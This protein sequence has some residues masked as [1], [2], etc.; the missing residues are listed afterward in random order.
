MKMFQ[1][2][3]HLSDGLAGRVGQALL[4]FPAGPDWFALPLNSVEAVLGTNSLHPLGGEL[5]SLAGY[6]EL[7]GGHIPVLNVNGMLGQ[8]LPAAQAN[9]VIL[10]RAGQSWAGLAASGTAETV[11]IDQ[12]EVTRQ[13]DSAESSGC[14]LAVCQ[15]GGRTITVLDPDKLLDCLGPQ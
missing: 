5:A 9:Q 10:L 1:H 8:D 7:N 6:V 13:S 12:S 4:V 15:V 2:P 14:A 3:T 11:G